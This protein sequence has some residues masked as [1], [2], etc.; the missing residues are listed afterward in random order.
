MPRLPQYNSKGTLTTQQPE[1]TR[2]GAGQVADAYGKVA[3]QVQAIAVKLQDAKN[4]AEQNKALGDFETEKTKIESEA[5]ADMNVNNAKLYA[6]RLVKA[7][8]NALQGIGTEKARTD[9]GLK[10]GHSGDLSL[11]RINADFYKKTIDNGL[12]GVNQQLEIYQSE[13]VNAQNDMERMQARVNINSAVDFNVGTLY[14]QKT[15]EKL[16]ADTI[17]E[18]Q[19]YLKDSESLRRVKE[20]ETEKAVEL[21]KNDNEKSLVYMKLNGATPEG[22]MLTREDLIGMARRQKNLS[23]EFR[24]AFIQSLKSPKSVFAIRSDPHFCEVMEFISNPDKSFSEIRTSIAY[25]RSIGELTPQDEARLES[26]MGMIETSGADELRVANMRRAYFVF[27]DMVNADS[28]ETMKA[29]QVKSRTNMSLSYIDKINVGVNPDT[30]LVEAM[31]EEVLRIHPKAKN[32]PLGMN[33]RDMYGNL[34]IIMPNG[35]IL[36]YKE[37]K[38]EKPAKKK[39]TKKAK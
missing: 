38:S 21:A 35:E 9:A 26:F 37:E 39:P 10:M 29:N 17:K 36:P 15:A 13:Y 28:K 19:N 11:I 5:S 2:T 6:D 33:V 30:A 18:A 16:K 24:D 4:V 7:R 31:R 22:A 32:Y 8:E 3:D 27:G 25:M 23:P 12:V 14:D 1:V 34:K 20:K